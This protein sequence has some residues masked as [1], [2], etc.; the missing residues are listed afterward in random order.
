MSTKIDIGI[1]EKDRKAIAEGLSK[2]LADSYTLYLMTHNFHWNVTGPMF[3]TLHL[4]FMTQYTEQWAALDLIAERIRAL[5]EP[6]PATYK[7][8]SKLTSI[9]EV[10]GVPK[11][12]EMVKLLV[13]AQEATS[14]TARK[15]F[16]LVEKAGDQPTADLLTQRQNIH[17]K[18]AWM[19][20]SLLQD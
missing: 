2:L 17:E 11:A 9:D 12:M 7:E 19:L 5:G 4:M 1:D 10:S 20:R 13:K 16:P 14:K 8:Y 6:A 18:T 3:N 15:L